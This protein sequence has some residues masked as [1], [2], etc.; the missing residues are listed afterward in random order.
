MQPVEISVVAGL[1]LG[2]SGLFYAA[3]TVARRSRRRLTQKAGG[4]A[5]AA[6]SDPLT[7]RLERRMEAI[8]L[9]QAEFAERLAGLAAGEGEGGE[10]RLQAMASSL[11]GLIKDKNATLETALA[12]L[13]QLRGRLKALEQMGDL[14]E[15]RG[16]FERLGLRL[17]EAQA[18][19]AA[20]QAATEAR[21][22]ALGSESAAPF[23]ALSERLAGLHAQKDDAVATVVARLTPLEARLAGIE[24]GLGE[25]GSAR[26]GLERLGARIEELQ[27][28]Q[29]ATEARLEAQA[30]AAPY[31][32]IAEQLT[33]LYAQKDATVEA[34]FARLA[35]LEARLAELQAGQAGLDPKAALDGFAARLEA[36]QARLADLETPGENPYATISEQLT[37]LYAQKDATVATVL[38]RL[39]P[40]EARLAELQAGQAGLDPAGGAR[41]LRRTAGGRC[42]AGCR[43]RSTDCATRAKIPLRRS[44]SS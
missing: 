30:D 8:E 7:W 36:L 1:A 34:V 39:A 24:G 44:P 32:T 23:A 33:R 35:P 15:A 38:A 12:G 5:E 22:A 19:Q 18:A 20:A 16:L 10:A 25:L 9:G 13:D 37:R 27:R 40:L 28:A 21:L 17:D 26:A 3:W 31:A 11:V 2:S 29:A 6:G 42:G 41:R 43:T 14:A 4:P